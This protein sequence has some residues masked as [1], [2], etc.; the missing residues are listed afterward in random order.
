MGNVDA[1]LSTAYNSMDAAKSTAFAVL[2]VYDCNLLAMDRALQVYCTYH[3]K[4]VA[5]I[6]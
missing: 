1:S 3:H 2:F 6:I 4:Q 5:I